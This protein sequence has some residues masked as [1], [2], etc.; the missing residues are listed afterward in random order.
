MTD[1]DPVNVSKTLSYWLRH[2]PDDA[3]LTLTSDGWTS[4]DALFTA[5]QERFPVTF[6]DLIAV[7]ELNDKQRF[8]FSA[9]LSHIRARQ[10][11]SVA[12]DL[13]LEPKV[14]PSWLFHGTVERFWPAIQA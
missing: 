12:V 10:G 1:F 8:E 11:H 6:D 5:L 13:A 14:P 3:G 2:R 7:V 4:S 9:D